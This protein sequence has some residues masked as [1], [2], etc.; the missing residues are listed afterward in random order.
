M[1]VINSPLSV[2]ECLRRLRRKMDPPWKI[3]GRRRLIGWVL[4]NRF[5]A[6]KRRQLFE[7][8]TSNSMLTVRVEPDKDGAIIYCSF[9]PPV[10]AYA[11]LLIW[12]VLFTSATIATIDLNV[13]A[14]QFVLFIVFIIMFELL[15]RLFQDDQAF[16]ISSV[17]RAVDP[18]AGVFLYE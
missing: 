5:Y 15:R 1:I 2:E 10:M 8:N 3:F 14:I 7:R 17:R 9:R 18:E 13:L 11:I 16:L 4:G 12:M 6:Y